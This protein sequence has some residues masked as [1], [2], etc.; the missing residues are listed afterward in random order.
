LLNC[1][2]IYKRKGQAYI[3]K[4]VSEKPP[5]EAGNPHDPYLRG[6]TY[7]VYHY[8]MKCRRPVGVSQ[9][10]RELA[11]SSSSVSEYHL[12]KLLQL[13]LIREEEG[14]YVI[15]KVVIENVIRIR[16]MSIPTQSSYVTFFVATLL[17]LIFFLRPSV[18]ISL[19]FFALAING[20]ALAI[21]IYETI[22]TLKRL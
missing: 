2:I 5:G 9:I 15:D 6:T 11:L 19:Y 18:F 17:I 22:K 7:R 12:K 20:S 16:K 3:G 13:G 4:E 10:Q 8:M 21:S 14:G 1:S